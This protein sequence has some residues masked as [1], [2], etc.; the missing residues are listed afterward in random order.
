MT[1]DYIEFHAAER[2]D[3]V[4]Y[5]DN[6]LAITYRQFGRDVRKMM[7]ALQGFGLTRG[8]WVGVGVGNAH[9]YLH[10]VI[11]LA[12]DRLGIASVSLFS[13]EAPDAYRVLARLS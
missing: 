12:L 8:A 11:L 4:A 7:T 5:V 13:K 6:G 9:Q 10:W 2:A 1:L 3:A